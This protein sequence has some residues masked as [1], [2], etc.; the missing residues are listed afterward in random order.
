[1]SPVWL[2]KMLTI[3]YLGTNKYY[4]EYEPGNNGK[5]YNKYC[6]CSDLGEHVPQISVHATISEEIF[7]NSI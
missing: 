1:M 7:A 5:D 3:N 2:L 6:M 4:S